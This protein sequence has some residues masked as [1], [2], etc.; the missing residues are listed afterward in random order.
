MTDPFR[1]YT[2]NMAG[3]DGNEHYITM[4]HLLAG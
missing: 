3:S 1:V 4:L 2:Q